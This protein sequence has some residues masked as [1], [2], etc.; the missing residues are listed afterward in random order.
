MRELRIKRCSLFSG[1]FADIA[2]PAD[3]PSSD[4]FKATFN[5]P[6]IQNAQVWHAIQSRLHSTDS[7]R[8]IWLLGSVQ[9][10]VDA[11]REQLP[12]RHSV[13]LN[14]DDS[15]TRFGAREK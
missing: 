5:P 12:P 2:F 14:V 10:Q 3:R 15:E 8:L 11:A 1:S 13:V 9:P 6:A 7:R 4:S